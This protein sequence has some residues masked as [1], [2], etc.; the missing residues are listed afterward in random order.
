MKV[1]PEVNRLC[2]ESVRRFLVF[3]PKEVCIKAQSAG[4]KDVFWFLLRRSY[5]SKPRVARFCERTL[6]KR[7]LSLF[8][9][10]GGSVPINRDRTADVRR[11]CLYRC[12][13]G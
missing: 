8:P 6:G 12:D 9:H 10:V 4:M 5:R 7:A 11:S 13:P 2:D 1:R 3:T